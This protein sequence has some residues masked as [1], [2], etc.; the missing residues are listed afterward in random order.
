MT[1]TMLTEIAK[2]QRMPVA[3]LQTEW[4]KLYGEPTRSRN[5]RFLF[6][7]LAWR[8]QELQHGGLSN[9]AKNRIDKLAPEFSLARTPAVVPTTLPSEHRLRRDLRL[10]TPGTVITKLYR[11]N[12]LRVVVRDDGVEFDGA[13]Y[14]SLTALAKHV[15]RSKNIN[16]PLFFGLTTR[17]RD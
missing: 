14:P 15:T 13:M 5:R 16:G 4:L 6:R 3:D 12:E 1:T 11:G 17:S 7:R 8:I 2:L 9:A 10:P